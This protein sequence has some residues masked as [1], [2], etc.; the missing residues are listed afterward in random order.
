MLRCREGDD[1]A[2]TE[3]VLAYQ[4]RLVGIFC[5]ML[6]D[7][8][9]AEDLAQEAFLRVYRARNGY[10][11]TAKFSTWLFRI[12]NNL[13][14][15]TRRTRGR[16]REVPLNV[17]DSGPLGPRP[18]EKLLAEKS[19]MMPTRQVDRREMQILVQEALN[20]LNERQRMALLLHKFEGMSYADIGAAM[21]LSPAAVKSLLSRARESLR[22][23]LEQ[24]VK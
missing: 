15:N 21:E 14:S 1:Q 11:P 20:G 9:A 13:A 5:H 12:A 7:P 22:Q 17:H 4:D 3:L 24:H 19:G 8:E 16:R 10:K 23:R 18:Q 2:F 6:D